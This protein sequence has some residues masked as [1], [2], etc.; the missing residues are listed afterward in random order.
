MFS[1]TTACHQVIRFFAGAN[2]LC[3]LWCG[4]VGLTNRYG[5][6]FGR[7][8][9]ASYCQKHCQHCQDSSVRL[10]LEHAIAFYVFFDDQACACIC[11]CETG[12][13]PVRWTSAANW[14][15][16]SDTESRQWCA[17]GALDWTCFCDVC[18]RVCQCILRLKICSLCSA[19][20]ISNRPVTEFIQI[21]WKKWDVLQP[22]RIVVLIY[23]FGIL[24]VFER[25]FFFV[26]TVSAIAVF[27]TGNR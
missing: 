16:S 23:L 9:F 15:P 17:V 6:V 3:A 4:T 7:H 5:W 24:T 12:V 8:Y 13:E 25:N 21:F 20:L 18:W 10:E 19:L 26:Y 14:S 1:L 2:Q 22:S 11:V 27:A